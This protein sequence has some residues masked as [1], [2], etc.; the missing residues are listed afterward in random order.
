[1]NPEEK[2]IKEIW[3]VINEIRNL[4]FAIPNNLPEN[5]SFKIKSGDTEIRPAKVLTIACKTKEY[6]MGTLEAELKRAHIYR[7]EEWKILRVAQEGK[8][9]GIYII[10]FQLIRPRFEELY[11]LFKNAREQ[12]I[13]PIYILT[14]V[15]EWVNPIHKNERLSFNIWQLLKGNQISDHKM[16]N[17][18]PEE[19][20]EQPTEQVS[21]E[22][23]ERRKALESFDFNQALYIIKLYYGKIIQILEAECRGYFN[24]TDE[25]LNYYYTHLDKIVDDFLTLKGFEELREAK[26]EL[27]ESL[28]GNIQDI[29]IEWEY[30]YSQQAKEFYGKI[31]RL[32]ITSGS[33]QMELSK[34]IE[35]MFKSIDE[36]IAAHIKLDKELMEE[37]DAKFRQTDLYKKFHTEENTENGAE[38]KVNSTVVIYISTDNGIYV[39]AVTKKP[40]YPIKGKRAQLV[41]FLNNAK[42]SGSALAGLLGQT[43]PL[44]SKEI[45]EINKN[46]KLKL[47]LADDLIVKVNTG[48]YKLNRDRFTIQFLE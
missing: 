28:V 34:E 41:R 46:F 38:Q 10:K 40:N 11:T 8:E 30:G 45:D 5:R 20:P 24:I 43:M 39:N 36:A 26:P 16:P 15:N 1:M 37:N 9:N 25:A 35:A 22:D 23:K 27:F 21:E 4:D 3:W 19:T 7:L 6:L 42:Q 48:G 13:E 2:L 47:I 32:Y 17:E 18:K 29:E 44:I 12:N 31:E 14:M 33:K